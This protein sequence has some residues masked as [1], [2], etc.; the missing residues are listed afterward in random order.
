MAEHKMTQELRSRATV[1]PQVV[2]RIRVS[3][4]L[5]ISERQFAELIEEVEKDPFF[6]VLS[7]VQGPAPRLVSYAPPGRTSLSPRFYEEPREELW[8][9][10]G[11][12]DVESF[13]AQ[14][15]SVL[16][17]IQRIGRERFEEHF[18]YARSGKNL[19]EAARECGLTPL[20]AEAINDF[21]L[22]FSSRAE[23]FNPS[24]LGQT[25]RRRFTLVGQIVRG[26][27]ISVELFSP[28]LARG[29]FLIHEDELKKW[30]DVTRLD[31]VGKSHLKKLLDQIRLINIRQSAFFR[32]LSKAVELQQGYLESG[33][34]GRMSPV[35]AESL[36]HE[37]NLAPSTVS[38]SLSGKSVLLPWGT[39]TPISTLLPGHHK[40]LLVAIQRVLKKAPEPLTDAKLAEAVY[41]D[42]HIKASRRSINA[43]RHELSAKGGQPRRSL[44][45]DEAS[46]KS[47]SEGG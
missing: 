31:K 38:R 5:S 27:E 13:L 44:H 33:D 29:R 36:A 46:A 12:F 34:E 47:G 2:G 43:C 15:S 9:S 23:F 1:R 35:S 4:L 18:L 20:E 26:R 37:L 11:S 17:L 16:E 14:R 10:D 8:A 6:R 25:S 30:C 40:V 3:Q 39:E 19:A 24:T 42:F 21:V 22:Q 7:G 45:H 41:R 32:I 28:H